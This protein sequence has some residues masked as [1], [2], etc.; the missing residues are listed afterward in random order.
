MKHKQIIRH[1]LILIFLFCIAF[2]L[3]FFC[4]TSVVRAASSQN[5]L[6]VEGNAIKNARGK[7]V[8][9]IGP[10]AAAFE[11]V[12]NTWHTSNFE[13]WYNE[14]SF[15]TIKS[16][17]CN[18]FRIAMSYDY[19]ISHP[20]CLAEYEK[21]VD[22]ATSLNMYVIV[23]WGL[24]GNPLPYEQYAATFFDA[25]SKR[26]ANNP[27]I[28]YEIINEPFHSTWSDISSYSSRIIPIIRNN[29]P[30][31][32]ILVGTPYHSSS[33]PDTP[34]AAIYSPLNYNNII[35]TTH[36]YTGQTLTYDSLALIRDFFNANLALDISEFGTT[37]SN[38]TDGHYEVPSV[39]YLKYLDKYN[40]SW[41]F[42]N[43]SDIHFSA[44]TFDSSICKPGQWTNSL[45]SNSLSESGLFLKRYITSNGKN[46]KL[47][48]YC[49]MMSQNTNYAF[50]SPEYRDKIRQVIIT[51]SSQKPSNYDISWD[52]SID[53]SGH[54]MAY[55]KGDVLY[56]ASTSGPVYA[57]ENSDQLFAYLHSLES[58]N[59]G[60]MDFSLVLN[61][62]SF[63]RECTSLK[64]VDFSNKSFSQL[65]DMTCAFTDCFQLSTISFYGC[66]MQKLTTIIG[67]FQG[68]GSLTELY[69]GNVNSAILIS[70]DNAFANIP[71][72]NLSIYTNNENNMAFFKAICPASSTSIR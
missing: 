20:D 50:W 40:I 24:C 52:V 35:Y 33:Q 51:T 62:R 55:L 42:F 58:I 25:L 43:M 26:Y 23:E 11:L 21:Y 10:G 6:H 60:N 41:Q 71:Q 39:I 27:Y 37:M 18:T 19:Y 1:F 16:W 9:L 15:S 45:T 5:A 32:V 31:S 14:E 46:Y 68:C 7:T 63:M 2:G 54:V 22:L 57:P 38:G 36:I 61:M 59:L 47:S 30:D 4:R 3:Y 72:S 28:L 53:Q 49:M 70:T 64:Q 48:N 13:D 69:M 66:N 56:I 12:H 29:A 44:P 67:T 65:Q 8:R 34:Y 17:G